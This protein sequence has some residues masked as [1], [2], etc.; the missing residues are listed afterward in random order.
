[1]R[2][3][4]STSITGQAEMLQVVLRKNGIESRLENEGGAQYAIGFLT[5][6]IPIDIVVAD[7]DAAEAARIIAEEFS[8]DRASEATAIHVQMTCA[9]GRIL[10]YPKGEEPPEEC[11]YC[12]R[13]QQPPPSA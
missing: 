11:P 7:E 3:I 4:Y 13:P 9:C 5:P 8:R 1:M 2:K 6:A 10:E 12:G